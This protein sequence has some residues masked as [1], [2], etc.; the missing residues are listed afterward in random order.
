MKVLTSFCCEPRVLTPFRG[1][2]KTFFRRE[3]E[4][5][6][7]VPIPNGLKQFQSAS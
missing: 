4:G 2:K 3:V 5:T 1:Q 6:T 7:L